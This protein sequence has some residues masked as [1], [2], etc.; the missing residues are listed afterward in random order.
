MYTYTHRKIYFEYILEYI[1]GDMEETASSRSEGKPFAF[2]A[3]CK[4]HSDH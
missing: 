1:L 4:V 2:S 3:C